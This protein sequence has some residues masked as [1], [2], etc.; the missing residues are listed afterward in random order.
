MNI[1]IFTDSYLPNKDGVVT[2]ILNYEKGLEKK[3]HKIFIFAPDSPLAKKEPQVYRFAAVQFPPYPEYRAAIFPYVSKDIATKKELSIIHC[4]AMLTMGIAAFSF[5]KRANLP[6]IASF[7]TLI[8]EGTHY[9]LPFKGAEK[10]GKKISWVYLRWFYKHF[11]KVTAPSLY[12]QKI[13][14]EN[15]IQTELLPSPVNTE[16]F[17]PNDKGKL[18]RKKFGL[19][20][21]KV[22]LSVGR[23]VKEKNYSFLLSV[24]KHMDEDVHFLIVGRGPYLDELK[25]QIWKE[26]LTSRFHLTGFID[27]QELP[28]YYNACDAF[29][30]PSTF[31]T[32][33]LT[34]LEAMACGKPAAVL[35]GT[36]MQEV[37]KEGKNGY[38]FPSDPKICAEKLYAC[39][40]KKEKLS[41]YARKTALSFSI[42]VCTQKLIKIYESVLV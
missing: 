33:G 1:A 3:G 4:K 39:I 7:H 37:I 12:M 14:A 6:A 29:V 26:G 20:R 24:A 22:V 27:E 36:P 21:K 19:E 40:E 32:Q 2:S 23:I 5:A 9:V 11:Q 42:P 17:K 31:E 41:S 18:I 8:P 38:T 16:L 13:L 35:E 10:L 28:D 15:N 25:N 30:F 34:H